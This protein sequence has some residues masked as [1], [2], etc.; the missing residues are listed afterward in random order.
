VLLVLVVK[1][2]LH[3]A[4]VRAHC[5]KQHL[6]LTLLHRPACS[7]ADSRRTSQGRMKC[8]HC[9]AKPRWVLLSSSG[10]GLQLHHNLR[11]FPTVWN[12]PIDRRRVLF[13][14]WPAI[15][16]PSPHKLG[17][18]VGVISVHVDQP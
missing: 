18:I 4:A 8:E 2:D 14:L 17:L 5:A 15:P 7:L 1:H 16:E 13:M 11:K 12:C 10:A 9:S 3:Y 6:P